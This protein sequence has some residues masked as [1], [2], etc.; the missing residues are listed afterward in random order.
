MTCSS[1]VKGIELRH[2]RPAGRV[3]RLRRHLLGVR[4]AGVG[5]NG[6]RQGAPTTRA[7]APSTSSRPTSSCLMHQKGCAERLGLPSVHPHRPDPERSTRMR[8]SAST[9]PRPRRSSS[10]RPST[11]TST[12]AGCGTC[13]RSAT[14]RARRFPSGRS[15]A[16]LASAIKEHTLTHL[17]DYLEEFE[18]NAIAN[19][20]HVHWAARRRRAQR[21]R[22]RHH[23]PRAAPRRWSRPS[24]C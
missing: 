16:A 6:L 19:G 1:A 24:R 2:A 11:S 4:G 21:D 20:A 8:R 18:R 22:A 13:A 17:A 15:C 7:P 12:T 9:T 5:E 10:P 3:L 14:A 23:A